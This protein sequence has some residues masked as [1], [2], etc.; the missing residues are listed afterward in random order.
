[1]I[2]ASHNSQAAAKFGREVSG[3]LFQKHDYQ[4]ITPRALTLGAQDGN[5]SIET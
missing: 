2:N 5:V 1:M 4:G 3:D